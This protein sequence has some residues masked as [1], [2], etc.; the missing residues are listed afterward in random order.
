MKT[1]PVA[2]SAL[3]AAKWMTG[4]TYVGFVT[5]FIGSVFATRAMGPD[6]YGI[7]AYLVWLVT[8]VVGLSTGFLNIT[9][10]RFVAEGVGA[11]RMDRV[12]ATVSWLKRLFW[13]TLGGSCAVLLV[14]G[15][16]PG[17][18]P[19][20]IAERLWFYL[21]FVVLCV[22]ARAT[23]SFLMSVSKGYSVFYPEAIASSLTGMLAA[24]AG[25]VLL[26]AQQS[27]MAFMALFVVSSV[28]LLLWGQRMMRKHGVNHEGGELEATERAR[29]MTVLRWNAVI[30]VVNLLSTKSADT[31]LLG[32]H[33]LTA[34]V[35]YYNI[36]WTMTKSGLD[37]LSA[38]YSSMLLPLISR[39]GGEG[40]EGKVQRIFGASVKFYQTVGIVVA[41]GAWIVAEP[42]V[43]MLYGN[44]FKEVIP[45]LKVMTLTSGITLPG[46]AYSAAFIATDSQRARLVF[47]VLSSVVSVVTSLICIPTWGYQG[48]LM[49]VFFGGVITY[50]V[51]AVVA[52]RM[53][54]FKFPMRSS[55]LQLLSALIPMLAIHFLIPTEH[56]LWLASLAGALFLVA[57]VV[58]ALNLNAWGVDEIDMIRRN[59]PRAARVIDR[60]T[61]VH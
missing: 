42:V 41:C 18:Y 28:F 12:G 39:A 2:Q 46:A 47:I 36:A 7:Y 16:F 6:G 57:F 32:L 51:I 55:L 8:L 13:W 21:A 1:R 34:Y 50:G 53:L 9:A 20:L 52:D 10:V 30:S 59:S 38:G 17:I 4:S 40:D 60:L 58:I 14:T 3:S 22:L 44:A 48:A 35:G 11:N 56:S 61:W 27:L 19:K 5:S 33:A 24:V 29:M 54:G 49:S 26:W 45:A 31:Y 37:L 25:A 43:T 23:F 15:F